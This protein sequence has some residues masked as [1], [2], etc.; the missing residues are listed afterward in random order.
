[1][2]L[3]CGEAALEQ[4]GPQV[5]DQLI[6]EGGPSDGSLVSRGRVV[7]DGC[8]AGQ[9]ARARARPFVAIVF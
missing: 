6:L 2:A 7:V 5:S 9:R 4:A 8:W 1:M 3:D